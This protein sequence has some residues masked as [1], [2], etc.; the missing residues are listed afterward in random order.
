MTENTIYD[1]A[2]ITKSIPTASLALTFITEGK[3][4]LTDT[5]K[6]YIPELQNDHGATI[7]DLLRYH[8]R[9]QRMST[10]SFKTFEQIRTHILEHGFDGPKTE[11]S[12]TNLPGYV[13]GVILERVGGTSLA[14]LS[15]TYFF[16]PLGMKST[17]FFPAKSDCAPTEVQDGEIVQG[18]AHDESTRVFAKARRSV[19]H[20]GLFSNA[21]DLLTF[22]EAL[23]QGKFPAVL[24]GAQ[25]GLGWELLERG[26]F[27]KTG[28]TGTNVALHPKTATAL[29]ILSNRTY[30]KRPTDTSAINAF[31]KDVKD[32]VFR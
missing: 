28:F 21:R 22:L 10:L 17:T 3:V 4:S 8:V 7:E 13:L 15:D 25:D 31:R 14:L 32:I 19:G 5:V 23:L 29:V 9:G 2:S 11:R 1:L 16:A 27:G 26:K 20:A 18:I 30:P 12:Y 24:K 6:K